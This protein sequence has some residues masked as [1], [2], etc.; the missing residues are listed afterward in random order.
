MSHQIVFLDALDELRRRVVRTCVALRG[1]DCA[2][3]ERRD[4]CQCGADAEQKQ[5]A[6]RSRTYTVWH[7]NPLEPRVD[8]MRRGSG[9][10]E[11]PRAP[12]RQLF[13]PRPPQVVTVRC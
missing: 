7:G 11:S 9:A 2:C 5:P 8:E 10:T 13:T 1:A 4:D 6:Q 12:Q 3:V